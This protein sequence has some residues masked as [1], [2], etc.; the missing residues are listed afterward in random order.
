M[1]AVIGGT[2]LQEF[3]EESESFKDDVVFL[4]RHNGMW[5]RGLPPHKI[6]YKANIRMLSELDVTSIIAVFAVGSLRKKHKPGDILI[7]SSFIDFT[8]KR[9]STFFDDEIHHETM[10]KEIFHYPP[11][12]LDIDA[13][14]GGT[15]VCIEGPRFSTVAES[16]MFR[17]WGGDIIGMTMVPECVLAKEAGMLYTPICVVTDYDCW[18]EHDVTFEMVQEVMAENEQKMIETVRTLLS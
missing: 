13:H 7:P 1:K 10:G 2:A 6:D 18:L 16:K 12:L 4:N 14:I 17:I 5:N 3:V 15:Y 8:K 11:S 9:E